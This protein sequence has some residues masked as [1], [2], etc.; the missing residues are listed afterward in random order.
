MHEGMRF[1]WERSL[2]GALLQVLA[3]GE[4]AGAAEADPGRLGPGSTVRD[5]TGG[6]ATGITNHG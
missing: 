5:L 2:A 6:W 1:L 3:R 4:P